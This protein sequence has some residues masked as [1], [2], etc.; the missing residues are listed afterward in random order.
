MLKRAGSFLSRRVSEGTS[1]MRTSWPAARLASGKMLRADSIMPRAVQV[2]APARCRILRRVSPSPTRKTC[3]SR[4]SRSASVSSSSCAGLTRTV[5]LGGAAPSAALGTERHAVLA[6][7]AVAFRL[8]AGADH[9]RLDL[10]FL[11]FGDVLQNLGVVE[12]LAVLVGEDAAQQLD[13]VDGD[14]AVLRRVGLVVLAGVHRLRRVEAERIERRDLLLGNRAAPA[15]GARRC[16]R[17]AW[18]GCIRAPSAAAS[19]AR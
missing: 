11:G 17:R 8:G 6:G 18:G 19:P 13:D 7:D 16:A 2:S 1:V 10:G 15:P 9:L 14:V 3:V 12:L 5:V 4:P